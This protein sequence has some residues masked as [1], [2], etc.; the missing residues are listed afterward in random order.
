MTSGAELVRL[1]AVR[2]GYRTPGAEVRVLEE[3]SL[4][5]RRGEMVAVVGASGVG[6]TTLLNVLG[7]MDRPDAG[8]YL[9]AGGDVL[10]LRE[11]ER[12]AFRNRR[13]G[14]V[15][16]SH[17]LLPEFDALENAALPLWIRGERDA[18]P[19]ARA[20][21]ERLGLGERLRHRP[22]QLSGGEQQRVAIARAFAGGPELILADEPT[23]DLDPETGERVFALLREMHARAGVT[24][25]LVT[26]NPALAARCD[27]ALVLERGRLRPAP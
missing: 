10:G 22:G 13:V 27:R 14:F 11:E 6:K 21:L 25:L 1:D 23:G 24:T 3:L 18:E 17:R 16:Q 8:R 26:H 15:F 9:F 2:K 5:I 4:A 12:A 19:R 20:I 7:L